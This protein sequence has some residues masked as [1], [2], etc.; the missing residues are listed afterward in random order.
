MKSTFNQP[1]WIKPDYDNYQKLAVASSDQKRETLMKF[2]PKIL[3]KYCTAT[4]ADIWRMNKA[5]VKN[6]YNGCH[7]FIDRGGSILAVAHLDISPGIQRHQA[8]FKIT[9]NNVVYSV[10]L[11]DRLGAYL[12]CDY[13]P[14]LGLNFD[15][16]L[17]ENEE[18]GMSTASDFKTTRDYN[19]IFEFDRR[20]NDVV[21]YEYDDR[22]LEKLLV[23]FGFR[24]GTGSFSDICY[25]E[26]LGVK[27][28]NFGTGYFNE[29]STTCHAS[30]KITAQQVDRFAAFF[31][32]NEDTK[33]HHTPL[34]YT[35]S[36][37]LPFKKSGK[38]QWRNY[39][40]KD[41]KG[42]NAYDGSFDTYEEGW[43][44]SYT[45]KSADGRTIEHYRRRGGGPNNTYSMTRREKDKKQAPYYSGGRYFDENGVSHIVNDYARA[46]RQ[47]H[48]E[49][50]DVHG[51]LINPDE[52][53]F[54]DPPELP[55]DDL[56]ERAKP[57]EMDWSEI[58]PLYESARMGFEEKYQLKTEDLT[59]EEYCNIMGIDPYRQHSWSDDDYI[60]WTVLG[61]S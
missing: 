29:H 35:Y 48:G 38:R 45:T 60:I 61:D 53:P 9:K 24:V 33:F 16:L 23:K 59:W 34:A 36:Q 20:G 12:L 25:L 27:A 46:D 6:G 14:R 10:A 22:D 40:A 17:T 54:C 43:H 51:E 15:V 8:S 19:W 18:L 26:D 37:Y 47:N 13:L 42:H 7:G 58:E 44:L 21:L 28:M 4:I 52:L 32:A 1:I 39:S 49:P 5:Q 3:H 31:K 57:I 50:I 2:D 41:Y 55:F 30:L 11:D 56:P